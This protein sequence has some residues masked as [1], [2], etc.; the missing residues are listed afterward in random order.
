[1]NSSAVAGLCRLR[2]HAPGTAFELAVPA[3]VPL[4]DLLPAVL[5]HAGPDLAESGLEHG[6][7]VLQRLGQE[8]LD[9][10]QSAEA[11]ALHDG[12]TLYLRP[13]R[14]ALPVVHFDDLVDGVATGMRERGDSWR[15]ALT[16]RLSLA[17]ALLAL[18][19]GWVVLAL[20][21]PTGVREAAAAAAALLLLLG[22]ASAARAMAD[23]GAGTALGAAAVPYLALAALLLPSGPS[24]EVLLGAR[25]LAAASAAAGAS[26]LA[27]AA[28]GGSAP[29]FLGVVLVA[30][31]GVL[32]G[33][34]VLAGLAPE[35]LVALIAVAAVLIGALVP[36]LAFRLSG[37]RLPMLPRNAEELQEN[38]E[39]FPAAGVLTRS[40]VAD[41]YLMA[42]YTAI[43]VVCA[44]CLTLL[45]F[46]GG[47]AGPAA[48]GALSVLLLLHARA[49]GSIRQRL[50]LLLPG[51]LGAVVLVARLT[52]AQPAAGRSAVLG[53]LLAVGAALLVVAW[54]VPGRRLLPYWGRLA[55]VLHTL[56][57]VALLPLALQA[58]G[59]FHA[60][61]T[62]SG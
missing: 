29:L 24:G 11:L 4:A 36:S 55:D 44:L 61:R 59:V 16:H 19:G 28:V 53:G 8:P 41:D 1:M 54:T 38:I 33:A 17:V 57:A 60:L 56:S 51:L 43:G 31:L 58:G 45:A 62:M 52:A 23:P 42:L 37:L 5:G 18:A 47:W 2:F 9:E 39:P 7:W 22:S 30:V 12:D 34:L 48:T 26:V 35:Q 49:V 20:P 13:R 50:A 14:E 40:L 6:G 10:E 46:A 27:V 25:V 32:G 15:P 21:G 3:D